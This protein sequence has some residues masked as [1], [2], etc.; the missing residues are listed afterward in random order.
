MLHIMLALF[1]YDYQPQPRGK[2][3][4]G[5]AMTAKLHRSQKLYNMI[6]LQWYDQFM[7]A[8]PFEDCIVPTIHT[9]RYYACHEP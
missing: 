6:A 4:H 9:K 2:R 5:E 8:W 1:S 3:R 7:T